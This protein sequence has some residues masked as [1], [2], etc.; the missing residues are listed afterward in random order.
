VVVA[1]DAKAWLAAE[2]R[3]R[4]ATLADDPEVANALKALGNEAAFVFMFQPFRI[5]SGMSRPAAN[6]P[7]S[8][9][10]VFSYGRAQADG[11]FRLDLPYAALSELLRGMMGR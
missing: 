10:V 3:T 6:K 1:S 2:A 4:P 5:M 8:S 9:P 7:A 11:W